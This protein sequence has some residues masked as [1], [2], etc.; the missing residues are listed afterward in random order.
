MTIKDSTITKGFIL[1]G[2]MNSSVLICLLYIRL[3][4]SV[5]IRK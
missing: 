5:P 3:F 2:L 1:A 4:T